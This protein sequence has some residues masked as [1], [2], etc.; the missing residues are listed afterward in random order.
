MSDQGT[1]VAFSEGDVMTPTG[2]TATINIA[3]GI[4]VETHSPIDQQLATVVL[5]SRN[6]MS[7]VESATSEAPVTLVGGAATLST[8][9]SSGTSI[10]PDTPL[11][12]GLTLVTKDEWSAWTWWCVVLVVCWNTRRRFVGSERLQVQAPRTQ[13]S[14]QACG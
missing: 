11:M 6:I 3:V 13:H 4:G 5:E 2:S 12:G 8:A 9:L 10:K 1:S 7:D 14:L